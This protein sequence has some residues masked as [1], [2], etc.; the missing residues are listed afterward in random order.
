MSNYFIDLSIKCVNEV[1]ELNKYLYVWMW[2]LVKFVGH[3][4]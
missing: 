4:K 3:N 2:N 1:W